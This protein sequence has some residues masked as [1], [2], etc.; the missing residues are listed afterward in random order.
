MDNFFWQL[1][2]RE[3]AAL[4]W[5]L[6]FAIW[7]FP[8]IKKDLKSLVIQLLNLKLLV[9]LGLIFGYTILI[10]HFLNN[11][12]IWSADLLKDTIYWAILAIPVM[13]Y[14]TTK[15]ISFKR[16]LILELGAVIS[17]SVITEFLVNFYTFNFFVELLILPII[18]LLILME[19]ASG[20]MNISGIQRTRALLKFVNAS[21]GLAFIIYALHRIIDAP[22]SFFTIDSLSTFGLPLVLGTALIP[23]LFIIAIISAYEQLLGISM[24]RLNNDINKNYIAFKI[25]LLTK[26]NLAKIHSSIRVF[27]IGLHTNLE[28][29]QVLD[30]IAK[31][32]IKSKHFER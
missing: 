16:F 15:S 6:I 20:Y 30:F 22:G 19:T 27:S 9:P 8:R 32:S 1:S 12:G 17:T 10:I 21:I 28:Q 7:V 23:V 24:H 5:T 18:T 2:T 4:F 31:Q 11:H 3:T 29:A 14:Q 25:I 13:I 26:L